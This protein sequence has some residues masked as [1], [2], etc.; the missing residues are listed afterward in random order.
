MDE[1]RELAGLTRLERPWLLLANRHAMGESIRLGAALSGVT[2]D[3]PLALAVIDGRAIERPSSAV[4]A[5]AA[6]RNWFDVLRFLAEASDPSRPAPLDEGLVRALHWLLHRDFPATQPG[7]VRPGTD[8]SLPPPPAGADGIG[9][10]I[11]T[12]AALRRADPCWSGNA[13]VA[14]AVEVLLLARA[15][16]L[17]PWYAGRASPAGDPREVLQATAAGHL[18]RC[19]RAEDRWFALARML[20]DK[21][22]PDRMAGPC[23]DAAA[24]LLVTNASYR[25]AA[26]VVRRRAISEQQASRDLK[27]LVEARLLRATGRTRDRTYAWAATR[28]PTRPTT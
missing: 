18:L 9:A 8:L 11:W 27:T 15:D 24:G 16:G 21:G 19:R 10:A 13:T 14:H 7:R 2:V 4:D 17:A 22:L 12:A 23:W 5:P 20:G 1:R 26:A 28:P 3:L 25:S 6:A